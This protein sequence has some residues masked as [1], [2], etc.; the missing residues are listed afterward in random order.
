MLL[1]VDIRYS[2]PVYFG[3]RIRLDGEVVQRAEEQRVV[4]LN[5]SFFNET[6]SEIAAR[7]RAQVKVRDE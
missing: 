4:V 7:C 3:N 1:S 5:V 2:K 6:R